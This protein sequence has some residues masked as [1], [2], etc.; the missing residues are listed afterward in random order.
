MPTYG[1]L[2]LLLWRQRSSAYWRCTPHGAEL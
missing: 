1:G 2:K